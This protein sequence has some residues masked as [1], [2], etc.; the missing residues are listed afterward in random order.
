MKMRLLFAPLLLVPLMAGCAQ[1]TWTKP[2]YGEAAFERDKAE[3]MYES[4]LAT[5]ALPTMADRVAARISL[6]EQ[7]LQ[8]RGWRKERN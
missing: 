6:V 2:G 1:T 7:C 4:D 8:L 3:C 5:A